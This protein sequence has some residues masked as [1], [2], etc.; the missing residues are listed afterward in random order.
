MAQ[1][2]RTVLLVDDDPQMLRLMHEGTSPR[3]AFEQALSKNVDGFQS[4]FSEFV[5]NSI[6]PA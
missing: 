5:D 3:E 4:R 6:R 2:T 1:P